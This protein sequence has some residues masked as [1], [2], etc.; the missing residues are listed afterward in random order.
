MVF[1]STHPLRG[2]TRH[3]RG[4]YAH[5]PDFNPRTPCGV[6]LCKHCWRTFYTIISIHAPLAG[7]DMKQYGLEQCRQNFNPRTPCGVRPITRPTFGI[8]SISIHAP[9]EGCDESSLTLDVFWKIFQSTHPLRGATRNQLRYVFNH[10]ISIHAP[11]AGCDGCLHGCEYCYAHFNPRTPCGVR[12]KPCR[13]RPPRP[14]FNPRTPCG[15]RRFALGG[16]HQSGAGISIHAPL[17]GCDWNC[18]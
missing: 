15:V 13:T 12:P 9:L 2:A 18:C 3:V 16:I 6:R 17:A 5:R 11:L 14:N 10:R 8:V 4:L 1:Q 7:C